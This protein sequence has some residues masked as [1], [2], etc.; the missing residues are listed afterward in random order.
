MPALFSRSEMRALPLQGELPPIDPWEGPSLES[1]LAYSSRYAGQSFMPGD[2]EIESP[3]SLNADSSEY[4]AWLVQRI[5]EWAGGRH[6]RILSLGPGSGVLEEALK[7]AG[8]EIV[9]VEPDAQFAQSLREKQITVIEGDARN[10]VNTDLA[11]NSFD[12]IL[13]SESLGALGLNVIGKAKPYLKPDGTLLIINLPYS[14]ERNQ[15]LSANQIPFFDASP[16]LIQTAFDHFGYSVAQETSPL[17]FEDDVARAKG[18]DPEEFKR[19]HPELVAQYT[20][21]A[22]LYFASPLSRRSEMRS[23]DEGRRNVLKVGTL[24]L[25]SLAVPGAT[26]FLHS[27][28]LARINRRAIIRE[29]LGLSDMELRQKDRAGQIDRTILDKQIKSPEMNGDMWGAMSL[30]GRLRSPADL[31]YLEQHLDFRNNTWQSVKLA[32]FAAEGIAKI[33]NGP[34]RATISSQDFDKAFDLLWKYVTR[35]ASKD[36]NYATDHL[37]QYER[38]GLM[39]DEWL[40]TIENMHAFLMTSIL[41]SGRV[42]DAQVDEVI[43]WLKTTQQ[44]AIFWNPK[45]LRLGLTLNANPHPKISAYVSRVAPALRSEMRSQEQPEQFQFKSGA[46]VG[47]YLKDHWTRIFV[48]L[49]AA[50][51]GFT[52][53]VD[54]FGTSLMSDQD[55]AEMPADELRDLTRPK[56]YQEYDLTLDER[57]VL[58]VVYHDLS[59]VEKPVLRFL[60]PE[61][62]L[63]EPREAWADYLTVYEGQTT[64]SA[65]EEIARDEIELRLHILEQYEMPGPD[66]DAMRLAHTAGDIARIREDV[67]RMQGVFFIHRDNIDGVEGFTLR[68]LDT[69]EELVMEVKGKVERPKR[70]PAVQPVIATVPPLILPE[71]IQLPGSEQAVPRVLDPI[72]AFTLT[73]AALESAHE[74][75]M[76]TSLRKPFP[77]GSVELAEMGYRSWEEAAADLQPRDYVFK[78]GAAGTR[79]EDTLIIQRTPWNAAGGQPVEQWKFS[80]SAFR[81]GEDHLT[82]YDVATME[83][84]SEE[85]YILEELL[86]SD[87]EEA[88]ELAA[89]A[90]GRSL[91]AFRNAKTRELAEKRGDLFEIIPAEDALGQMS[92]D[93]KPVHRKKA[94]QQHMEIRFTAKASDSGE[95]RK[96]LTKEELESYQQELAGL[97]DVQ[98]YA[99][100]LRETRAEGAAAIAEV[101]AAI[102]QHVPQTASLE[103]LRTAII[104]E[105]AIRTLDQEGQYAP[106]ASERQL[107]ELTALSLTGYP[108]R[109]FE[110]WV[111]F[112]RLNAILEQEKNRSRPNVVRFIFDVLESA[113]AWDPVRTA[114]IP[115]GRFYNQPDGALLW[116][117]HQHESNQLLAA[118]LGLP[119]LHLGTLDMSEEQRNL[120]PDNV[121]LVTDG[122]KAGIY[123]VT[124]RPAADIP[125]L[126]HPPRSLR[127]AHDALNRLRD[128]LGQG[129]K[130]ETR[131]D[132]LTPVQVKAMR[133]LLRREIEIALF[134]KGSPAGITP[135]TAPGAQFP[136]FKELK[137]FLKAL[138]DIYDKDGKR[139]AKSE[140]RQAGR[141]GMIGASAVPRSG[142]RD[143]TLRT[144]RIFTRG[145]MSVTMD[146]SDVQVAI[147]SVIAAELPAE[148]SLPFQIQQ[149]VDVFIARQ[150]IAESSRP[151][152]DHRDLKAPM[153]TDA[154]EDIVAALAVLIRMPGLKYYLPVTGTES[155]YNDFYSRLDSALQAKFQVTLA[156][157]PNFKLERVSFAE[158]LKRSINQYLNSLGKV[159][160]A[161]V[162]SPEEGLVQDRGFATSRQPLRI[163]IDDEKV[164]P[165]AILAAAED[166]SQQA[167]EALDRFEAASSFVKTRLAG[168]MANLAALK[169][170]IR[171]A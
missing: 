106:K 152:I 109:F 134:V 64:V 92:W 25:L 27:Q 13:M 118:H 55:V 16:E 135:G 37:I 10:L 154:L 57:G 33:L 38:D 142:T 140:M 54:R 24:A 101:D 4:R 147:R 131:K 83:K 117:K 42:S 75:K 157:I 78:M 88:L 89:S 159:E 136:A 81:A 79:D 56:N 171:S 127:A 52:L 165:A 100:Y 49:Q 76:I 110:S 51:E 32:N 47:R 71:T 68:R 21:S 116:L 80:K 128:T 153:N 36:P 62:E 103:D 102:S 73:T 122:Q 67:R 132:E 123:A 104:I 114:Q 48:P 35:D 160:S 163:Q 91:R 150:G 105:H 23:V 22:T 77:N 170:V 74:F 108:A 29:L 50:A 90:D 155:A 149:A 139:Q 53:R 167:L 3:L 70:P 20:G 126:E 111:M 161:A 138:K 143:L 144:R 93:I 95:V 65:D 87:N 121:E 69:R 34:E 12:L 125:A 40:M 8:H 7:V 43:Q 85:V 66:G 156:Q 1:G 98:L 5:Q 141:P 120:L 45:A 107:P 86:D 15:W 30:L 148:I 31:G 133:K 18:W 84:N 129:F 99:L 41:Q 2:T 6:L 19:K 94:Q 158:N 166:L 164:R 113:G 145:V 61:P 112:G 17:F 26:W 151:V 137:G 11:E 169:A 72:S 46:T 162:L 96:P 146:A 168:L 58:R 44:K 63:D 39:H 59:G 14:E 28:D 119:N 124:V 97:S 82:V 60:F 9:A 115:K 130:V